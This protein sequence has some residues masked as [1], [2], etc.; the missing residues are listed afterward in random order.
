M[1]RALGE[2]RETGRWSR[3]AEHTGQIVFSQLIR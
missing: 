2:F 1:L 3:L